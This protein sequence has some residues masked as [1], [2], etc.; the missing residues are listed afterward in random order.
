MEQQNDDHRYGE[1]SGSIDPVSLSSDE[2]QGRPRLR[3][4]AGG[5]G[6]HSA[7]AAGRLPGRPRSQ[8]D[9]GSQGRK[10]RRRRGDGGSGDGGG[11][12]TRTWRGRLGEGSG[13]DDQGKRGKGVEKGPSL[14]S[15]KKFED[16]DNY[17]RGCASASAAKREKRK[18][19][20]GPGGTVGGE[21]LGGTMTTDGSWLSLAEEHEVRMWNI[22]G[23]MA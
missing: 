12:E 14:S 11:R 21:S 13:D 10:Q 8:G 1:Q 15:G 20:L 4:G 19:R 9:E 22:L 2:M 7:A 6:G 16:L 5:S 18:R 23:E 17:L 3:G